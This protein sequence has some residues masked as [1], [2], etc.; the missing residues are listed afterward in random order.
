MGIEDLF[1]NF[2]IRKLYG[3]L[4][5]DVA[6][7]SIWNAIVEL[8][9]IGGSGILAIIPLLLLILVILIIPLI[10]F[11]VIGYFIFKFLKENNYI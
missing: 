3:P 1:S 9:K 5:L 7:K 6:L 11:I 8:W 4:F 10:P 2:V